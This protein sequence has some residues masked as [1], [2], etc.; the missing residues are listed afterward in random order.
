MHPTFSS[1]VTLLLLLLP[2]PQASTSLPILLLRTA[3]DP[4]TLARRSAPRAVPKKA[5]LA[6]GRPASWRSLADQ[7]PP[8]RTRTDGH[9][10]ARCGPLSFS[11]FPFPFRS[12]FATLLTFVA[13]AVP[14]FVCLSFSSSLSL[15]PFLSPLHYSTRLFPIVY[16]CPSFPLF[17]F[18]FLSPFLFSS[19]SRS[20]SPVISSSFARSRFFSFHHL[21]IF[22]LSC[23]RPPSFFRTRPL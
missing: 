16:L 2:P 12:R 1:I 23:T 14:L 13:F 19:A 21:P 6:K 18:F 4:C 10:C 20:L 9:A 22:S 11:F 3:Y 5:R 15:V 17:P 7:Y 8:P